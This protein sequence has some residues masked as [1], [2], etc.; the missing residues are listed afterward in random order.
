MKKF[1][2]K[3]SY[4]VIIIMILSSCTDD[5]EQI[6]ND[7]RNTRNIA[8]DQDAYGT[9]QGMIAK[10]YG[11]FIL[12]GQQGPAGQSDIVADDEG[13]T[14]YI[15]QYWQVQELCT[16]EAI[17][18]WGD[19][20]VD[21]INFNTWVA[22]NS[23]VFYIYYRIYFS[24][25]LANEFLRESTDELLDSRNLTENQKAEVRLYRTEARFLRGLAY[26]HAIDLFGNVGLVTEESPV[27]FHLPPRVTRNEL[28]DYVEGELL[29]IE[30]AM[31]EP[32][33]V[34]GR[35]DKGALWMLLAK[36]YLNAEVY[37]EE[38]RYTEALTYINKVITQGGYTLNNDYENN[39]LADNDTSNEIIFPL[40]SDGVNSQSFGGTTY[41]V[42]AQIG[43][44]MDSAEF[45]MSGGW[46]GNRTTSAFVNK[47]NDITGDTDSRAMFWT[48]GQELETTIPNNFTY[49]YAITKWKNL[50]SN[51]NPGSDTA[52]VQVDTDFPMFR[53]GDAYL[54][55]AEAVVR[56]GTGGSLT[57]AVS[58]V[59]E[60]RERA[61][62]DT[63]GNITSG[64]LTLSFIIDE[65]ARELYWEGH[66][67]QD[68]I[69]FGLYSGGT[70]NWPWKGGSLNGT[71]IDSYLELYPIPPEDVASNPNLIQ[72]PG[73][74]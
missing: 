56:G 45:G 52:G 61:Y 12:T 58:Y 64:D 14:S 39:F 42:N 36:L 27:G 60:L 49:G 72:N 26:Y 33:S 19:P 31:R 67:R 13:F 17:N 47:F 48:Q 7:D 10:L 21:D 63:S 68:L 55:Y 6:P 9:Y 38:P 20:G 11:S 25:S 3:S 8:F 34:Y 71:S 23:V 2:N 74:N 35:A 4:F 69:R 32:Q 53:L 22:G 51:G 73:Y 30:D 57:D 1:L 28:F 15:R 29:A 5:L 66:R 46:G 70:Y 59:N 18:A 65:R 16:D 50:T 62:G 41:L 44:E 37:T 24:V 43:G 54:M 40:I